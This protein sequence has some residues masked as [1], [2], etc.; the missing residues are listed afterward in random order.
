MINKENILSDVAIKK[1]FAK[2]QSEFFVVSVKRKT[3]LELNVL[4]DNCRRELNDSNRCYAFKSYSNLYIIYDDH[5]MTISETEAKE[6]FDYL[7][8]EPLDMKE[9][10]A[11]IVKYFLFDTLYN[12]IKTITRKNTT[13]RKN[14]E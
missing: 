7:K 9:I 1:L 10:N 8:D 3:F 12:P 14:Y 4:N 2:R 11:F 5:L 13:K 6:K